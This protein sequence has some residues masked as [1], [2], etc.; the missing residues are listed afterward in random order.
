MN[1]RRIL[2]FAVLV[3]LASLW[4]MAAKGSGDHLQFTVNGV[5]FTYDLNL[6]RGDCDAFDGSSIHLERGQYV[7]PFTCRRDRMLVADMA[8]VFFSGNVRPL[9]NPNVTLSMLR[10]EAIRGG[11]VKWMSSQLY[12]AFETEFRTINGRRWFVSTQFED[13]E[14]NRPGNR[15][16]W[17]IEGGLLVTVNANILPHI[18]VSREWRDKRFRQ[19]E[20]LVSRVGISR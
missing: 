11:E 3:G 20:E 12:K 9:R 13:I 6:V 19:L 15:T 16:Y 5:R 1:G 4:P 2:M 8:R 7:I 18:S 17:T 14:K 10:S